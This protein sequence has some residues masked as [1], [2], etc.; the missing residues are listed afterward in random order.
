MVGLPFASS[1]DGPARLNWAQL[2]GP[3]A[4]AYA[5]GNPVL[6][7]D[8]S[9]LLVGLAE[10]ITAV[11]LAATNPAG[12]A[13]EVGGISGFIASLG[14]VGWAALALGAALITCLVTGFL[15]CRAEQNACY[16]AA[17][18]AAAGCVAACPAGFMPDA[19]VNMA[20]CKQKYLD[21]FNWDCNW[22]TLGCWL[23]CGLTNTVTLPNFS[24]SPNLCTD[25]CLF[26]A[27][28]LSERSS[29]GNGNF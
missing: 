29:G 13:A 1:L 18:K 2:L 19:T 22:N 4:Y 16:S 10:V 17:D 23:H 21:K 7:S 5:G 8:P 24:C 28:L 12:A 27:R 15:H 26:R 6:Y 9:G 3:H 20:K 25:L 14:P 11:A